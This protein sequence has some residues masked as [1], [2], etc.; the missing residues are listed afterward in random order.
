M[1]PAVSHFALRELSGMVIG[2]ALVL[3]IALVMVLGI[4]LAMVNRCRSELTA[5]SAHSRTQS[6]PAF[7]TS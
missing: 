7:L 2:L 6:L 1:P 3:V 4:V 5:A